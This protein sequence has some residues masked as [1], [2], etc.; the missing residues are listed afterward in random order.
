MSVRLLKIC[1]VLLVAALLLFL[2]PPP[3]GE[4]AG[5]PA[6]PELPEDGEK[7]RIG[8]CEGEP[9]V[10]FAG[11][12]HGLLTGLDETGW[13]EDLE[14]LP[15]EPGQEDS[16][17]M[18]QY[19]AQNEKS[20]YLEFVEDAHYSFFLE[21][22]SEEELLERLEH[23][24]D[25]DLV[26]VM[27][28]YAGV[29]LSTDSHQVPVLVFSAS[30]PLGS[31]IVE[32]VD[33]SGSPHVWAHL[34][35]G[36]DRRQ[37]EVFYDLFEFETM[38]LVYEDS[39]L[40]RIF[41]A[42]DDVEEVAAEQGFDIARRFVAEPVDSADYERYY[43]ELLSAHEELA[44][45]VD[46]FYLS[47]ASIEAE[48]L[49]TLLHPFYRHDI[50]VFSQLGSG[51][52]QYGALASVARAD[53]NDIGIFGAHIIGQVL[54]GH[55]PRELTQVYMETPNIALNLEVAERVGYQVPFEVM[56]VADLIYHEIQQ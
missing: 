10:N 52:V 20:P 12:L 9:F 40:G 26:I 44:Q 29:A 18:W 35:P 23:E 37:V 22:E 25:L 24:G 54:D 2:V 28:T 5:A 33:D 42:I 41:S 47:I 13:I 11:H 32:S 45:E 30:D 36:R 17:V 4:Q 1:S 43:S 7:W 53:F 50:P 38:G 8:Y 48:K 34:D 19:L 56:L 15:Y 21:P 3:R 46:A 6:G 27:G 49:P 14:G 55:K 51:E 16:R 39:E 31:G